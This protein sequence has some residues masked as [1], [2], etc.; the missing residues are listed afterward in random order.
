M[1]EEGLLTTSQ[2]PEEIEIEIGL[3]L[4]DTKTSGL[5]V[6]RLSDTTSALKEYIGILI[7]GLRGWL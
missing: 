3:R 2:S 7:Y 6:G 5:L 1:R 4:Y